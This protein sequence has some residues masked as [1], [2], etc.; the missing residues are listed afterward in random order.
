MPATSGWDTDKSDAG[1]PA[2]PPASRRLE[3]WINEHPRHTWLVV[4]VLLVLLAAGLAWFL[5]PAP[6]TMTFDG[7]WKAYVGSEFQISLPKRY[8]GG[9][10]RSG[11]GAA[12][13]GALD[14]IVA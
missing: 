1:Q 10:G 13:A 8:V 5:R 14:L 3:R 6:A 2:P 12:L 4:M 11:A 7:P 9:L